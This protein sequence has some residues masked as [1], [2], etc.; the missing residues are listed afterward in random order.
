MLQLLILV[1]LLVSGEAKFDLFAQTLMLGGVMRLATLQVWCRWSGGEPQKI[2]YDQ[3][4]V[5]VA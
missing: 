5:T 1:S 4:M 2:V 3:P